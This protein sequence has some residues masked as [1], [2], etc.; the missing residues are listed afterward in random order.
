MLMY[1]ITRINGFMYFLR[2]RDT[3]SKTSFQ[4]FDISSCQFSP[5]VLLK[6]DQ[7]NSYLIVQRWQCPLDRLVCHVEST[8]IAK[9]NSLILHIDVIPFHVQIIALSHHPMKLL[10]TFC[11]PMFKFYLDINVDCFHVNIKIVIKSEK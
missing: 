6:L 3:T 10:P 8:I 4:W 11:K 9:L 1:P 2:G 5:L 7:S